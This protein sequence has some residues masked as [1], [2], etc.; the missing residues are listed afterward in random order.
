MFK[1]I[2]FGFKANFE[3]ASTTYTVLPRAKVIIPLIH[4]FLVQFVEFIKS[5]LTHIWVGCV[6]DFCRN[7]HSIQTREEMITVS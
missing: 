3:Y 5:N 4:P 7:P 6:P 1:Y 2:S